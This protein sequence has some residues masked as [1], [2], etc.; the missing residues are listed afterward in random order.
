[1][2]RAVLP[3]PKMELRP[4]MFV[5]AFMHGA[6]RPNAI[7]VPQLAIQQGSDGH[8]VY[9][10]NASG[11]A[12]I[13]PVVVGDYVGDQDIVVVQGLHA[14]DRVVV[15]GVLKVVPGKPV[16][17][18]AAPAAAARARA[19]GDACGRR[20]RQGARRAEEVA[21]AHVHALLHRPADPVVGHLDPDRARGRG[22][23][24]RVADRAIPG[25]GAARRCRSPRATPA[26]RRT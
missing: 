12:E 11:V 16:T 3:N 10:V 14:G 15:D 4:G 2:V 8:L 24:E 5:T 9:V 23:D 6:M 22:R 17:I 19:R 25:T 20:R 13:R 18:V 26:R 1:M 7:V 21:A